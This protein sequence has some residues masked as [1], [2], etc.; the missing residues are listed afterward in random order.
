MI[1]QVLMVK[2][3]CGLK[4]AFLFSNRAYDNKFEKAKSSLRAACEMM[5][6]E[7]NFFDRFDICKYSTTL[8][9]ISCFILGVSLHSDSICIVLSTK[10]TFT[11]RLLG[12]YQSHSYSLTEI[13]LLRSKIHI[14]FLIDH[15]PHL[16]TI[17]LQYE[18]GKWH[19]VVSEP[20][21]GS[22]DTFVFENG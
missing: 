12:Q 1:E 8:R 13:R 21:C 18:F 7:S 2:S 9:V 6:D 22:V 15:M 20:G 4:T 3:I 14:M 10:K 16:M 11:V 17:L 19:M 5:N